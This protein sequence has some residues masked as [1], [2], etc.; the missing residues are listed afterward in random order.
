[1]PNTQEIK[2]TCSGKLLSSQYSL[3]IKLNHDITC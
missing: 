1:M 2:P 3:N